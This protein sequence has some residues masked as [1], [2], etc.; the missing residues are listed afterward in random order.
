[1][2]GERDSV[3]TLAAPAAIKNA[4]GVIDAESIRAAAP[5]TR[6]NGLRAAPFQ[7][8]AVAYRE[9]DHIGVFRRIVPPFVF[10]IEFHSRASEILRE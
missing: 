7:L 1:V 6:A 4:F 3:A 10:W 5:W 8:R 9:R 2:H